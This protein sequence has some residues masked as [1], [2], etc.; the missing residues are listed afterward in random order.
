MVRLLVV[1]VTFHFILIPAKPNCSNYREEQ[2]VIPS[3]HIAAWEVVMHK[4][5]GSLIS[6]NNT[7]TVNVINQT[8]HDPQWNA[9]TDFVSEDKQIIEVD[10]Y[11][12]PSQ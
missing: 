9:S 8:L 11:N 3:A 10:N 5:L 6:F 7:E 4:F 1:E 12:D 2:I